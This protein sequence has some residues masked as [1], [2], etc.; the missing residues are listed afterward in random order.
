MLLSMFFA[1]LIGFV[2]RWTLLFLLLHKSRNA[3]I[4]FLRRIGLPKILPYWAWKFGGG[5][6]P[7]WSFRLVM[8]FAL[9][10]PILGLKWL[11]FETH[12]GYGF[13]I[14][15][16]ISDIIKEGLK[17]LRISGFVNSVFQKNPEP[18]EQFVKSRPKR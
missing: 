2:V 9:F 18:F 3:W 15:F 10:V 1:G 14:G 12:W 16:L 6:V 4:D 7:T 8:A 11:G 17:K 5:L 13:L